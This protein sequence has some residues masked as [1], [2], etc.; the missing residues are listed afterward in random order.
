MTM[1]TASSIDLAG[2]RAL[3]VEDQFLIA[4]DMEVMLRALGAPAVDLV[5]GIAD[6][7]AVIERAPPDFAIVDLNLGKE[8]MALPIA[9]ALHLRAIPFVF[10]TAYD[11]P[12]MPA[13][14]RTAPIIRKPV[15]F[16]ALRTALALLPL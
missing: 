1:T 10:V 14:M 5:A 8:T 3:V 2:R 15:P 7:L 4:L 9:E 11:D 16:D 6:A 13:A 12:A